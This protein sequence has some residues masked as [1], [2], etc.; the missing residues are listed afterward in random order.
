MIHVRKNL[1]VLCPSPC[2]V[3]MRSQRRGYF[4]AEA[5]GRVPFFCSLGGG[6]TCLFCLLFGRAGEG[7]HFFAFAIW[8]GGCVFVVAVGAGGVFFLCCL[9][10][11]GR[12]RVIGR[13]LGG[14]CFSV[15]SAGA[16]FLVL[17]VKNKKKKGSVPIN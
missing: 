15:W 9:G 8:A 7:A 10:G 1:E 6:R 16:C 14:S 17:T 13:C 4:A 3:E 2:S 5:G 12:L 11:P